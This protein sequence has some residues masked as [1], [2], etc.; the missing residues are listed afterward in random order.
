MAMSGKEPGD[1]PAGTAKVLQGFEAAATTM[2]SGFGHGGY[3]IGGSE[4][5]KQC[6]GAAS[7]GSLVPRVLG[8]VHAGQGA[9]SAPQPCSQIHSPSSS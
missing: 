4:S 6:E 9:T 8:A 5:E 1:T 3:L 2:D 7:R